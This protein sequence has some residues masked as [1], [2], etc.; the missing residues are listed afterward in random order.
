MNGRAYDFNLGRFLSIDPII[1]FPE[2]SQSLN[3]YSYLMN[4]PMA[5]TDPTGYMSCSVDNPSGCAELA[6]GLEDG[7]TIDVEQSVT[8]SRVRTVKVG[9]ISNNGGN[10]SVSDGNGNQVASTS[11]TTN[12]GS[13]PSGGGQQGIAGLG[14]P[15]QA[16]NQSSSSPRAQG[17]G[18]ACG[19]PLQCAGNS[20][21]SQFNCE[22]V[23]SRMAAWH[24]RLSGFLEELLSLAVTCLMVLSLASRFAVF[25]SVRAAG[26]NYL[27][28]GIIA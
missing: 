10:V 21:T 8:G 20:T 19:V 3:P 11:G 15:G 9:E 13:G 7:G 26:S 18:V 17:D 12:T 16:G 2:N 24:C 14:G 22:R 1:Q 28:E 6:E 25:A 27:F 23:I 5:G 4:N